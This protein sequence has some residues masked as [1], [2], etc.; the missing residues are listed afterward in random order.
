MESKFFILLH[1]IPLGRTSL[2]YSNEM[3]FS[4]FWEFHE[5][6]LGRDRFY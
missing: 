3:L 1:V 2:K 6:T 4:E 5:N